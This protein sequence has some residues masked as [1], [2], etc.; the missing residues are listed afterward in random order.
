MIYT[1]FLVILGVYL[2]QEYSIPNV[3]DMCLYVSE[4]LIDYRERR[5]YDIT[6][7]VNTE[8]N[9]WQQMLNKI[10]ENLNM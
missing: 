3:R 2:G 5:T 6:E 10:R 9:V 8:N 7:D 1:F 4:K